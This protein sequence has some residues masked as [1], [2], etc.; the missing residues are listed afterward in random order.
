MNQP[1]DDGPATPQEVIAHYGEG[2][3]QHRLF[4]GIG[5]LE[6]ARMEALLARSLP[7]PPAKILDVGDG[8]G[9]YACWLARR[10]YEVHLVDPVPLHIEQAT[11]ASQ[12]QSDSPLASIRLGDARDLWMEDA[13]VDA[14]LL[15]GPLYHLPHREDRSGA[16][17]E[18]RRVLR[19]G[20]TLLAVGISRFAALIDGLRRGELFTEPGFAEFVRRLL[21]EGRDLDHV[22]QPGDFPSAYLHLP[23]D[24]RDEVTGAGFRVEHIVAVEALAAAL[25][26]EVVGAFAAD[27]RDWTQLLEFLG[28]IEADESI[29]GATGHI[30]VVARK[31]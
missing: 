6:R 31:G 2:R 7:G 3:E 28:A 23:Q 19:P 27:P 10:G 5:S 15:F 14:V 12:A 29:L 1:P 30:L 9:H 17:R 16:L 24:L 20:A 13:S 26:D 11:S 18:A 22:W 25:P 8:P 21:P 4:S